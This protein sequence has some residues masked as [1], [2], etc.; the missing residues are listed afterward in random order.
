VIAAF[1]ALRSLGDAQPTT[2]VRELTGRDAKSFETYATEAAA[3]GAWNGG[4][5]P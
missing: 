4:P 3:R 1:A 5:D 2:V